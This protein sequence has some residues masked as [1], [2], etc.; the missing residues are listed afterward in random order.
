LFEDYEQWLVESVRCAIDNTHLNWIIKVHPV[1]VWR[2]KMDGAELEQL[3]A[4][5]LRQH[6]GE[7]PS[8]IK[9]MPA[10][11]DINTFSLFNVIDYGLTVRG[12]IG[13]ELPCFG[14]PVIT[15]GTGR[16]SER[17]FT[18]DP[19]SIEAFREALTTLH[20]TPKLDK[21]SISLARKH[22]YGALHLRPVPMDSFV[23]DFNAHTYG[24]SAL[25]Q[26]VNIKTIINGQILKLVDIKRLVS[27]I[28]DKTKC[29]LL[30]RDIE[31]V[32]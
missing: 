31:G 12:T 13:M 22:Y 6:F 28:E 10:D 3:E 1:N 4:I 16:Y 27:W 18:I 23:L 11:T 15:A 20:T 30:S 19:K 24:L 17:G 2:S 5:T 7:L 14:I 26:N 25:T 32:G 8:H 9:F 29:E 21:L